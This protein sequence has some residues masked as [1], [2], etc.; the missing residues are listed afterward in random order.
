[1]LAEAAIKNDNPM[2]YTPLPAPDTK[3]IEKPQGP[4]WECQKCGRVR[5]DPKQLCEPVKI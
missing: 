1:M 3:P 5:N 2:N 4:R